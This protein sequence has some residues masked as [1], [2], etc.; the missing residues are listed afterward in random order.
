MRGREGARRR[1][2]R[3]FEVLRGLRESLLD[4]GSATTPLLVVS[5]VGLGAL[6]C[7]VLTERE[8]DEQRALKKADKEEALAA[9]SDALEAAK[10]GHP[11]SPEMLLSRLN[12]LYALG[13]AENTPVVQQAGE[14]LAQ[15][16]GE[17]VAERLVLTRQAAR[18]AESADLSYADGSRLAESRVLVSIATKLYRRRWWRRRAGLVK[19]DEKLLGD[20]DACL[21]ELQERRH[22]GVQRILVMMVPSLPTYLLSFVLRFCH[23]Q[24]DPFGALSEM[25]DSGSDGMATLHRRVARATTVLFLQCVL[26]V[27]STSLAEYSRN[28]FQLQLHDRVFRAVLNQDMS[29]FDKESPLSLHRY[30]MNCIM[31]CTRVLYETPFDFVQ[32]LVVTVVGARTIASTAPRLFTACIVPIPLAAVF[33]LCLMVLMNE[34]DPPKGCDL[35][36]IRTIREHAMEPR[37]AMHEATAAKEARRVEWLNSI[38]TLG[39]LQLIYSVVMSQAIGMYYIGG[40][41]LVAGELSQGRLQSLAITSFTLMSNV[42]GLLSHLHTLI[43]I[44]TPLSNVL[45]MIDAKPVIE[46]PLDEPLPEPPPPPLSGAIEFKHVSF[47]YPFGSREPVLRDVSFRVNSG[48][49]VALVGR[50]GCGKTTLIKLLERLYD[51]TEGQI[52]VDGKPLSSYALRW[53]RRQVAVVAQEPVLLG[54]TLKEAISYGVDPAPSDEELQKACEDANAW[55]FIEAMEDRL[56]TPL[57]TSKLSGG[58]MQ[59]IAIARAIVRRPSILILDEATSAL[60]S[61]SEGRVQ[62]GLDRIRTADCVRAT[63]II[64]HRLQTVM[65]CNRIVVFSKR[66]EVV[67]SGGHEELM[68]VPVV[69]EGD[70]VKQGHYRHMW[71]SQMRGMDTSDTEIEKLEKAQAALR[72]ENEYLRQQLSA[73][74]QGPGGLNPLS[75]FANK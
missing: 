32:S 30:Q 11:P 4:P 52:L 46:P 74:S 51:P 23:A 20:V 68:Q 45:A 6:V 59:C 3:L 37:E 15:S 75:L 2:H 7:A 9:L 55:E 53:F 34:S 21:A 48:E 28:S 1:L 43:K 64:A 56:H 14:L 26:Q 66:G 58:Q 24:L 31:E 42:P 62:Q 5:G 38:R 17:K 65:R 40:K 73:A 12:Q 69:V 10:D 71:E 29:Y 19:V 27:L 39:L 63:V 8:S 25:L 35:R 50:R 57:D 41:M 36:H 54:N 33:G 67:E 44:R 70:E 72:E 16:L 61:V 60:D 18:G 49:Q 47:A 13:V 22:T